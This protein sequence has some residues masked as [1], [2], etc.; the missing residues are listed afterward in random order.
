MHLQISPEVNAL[1]AAFAPY[2]QGRLALLDAMGLP[3]SN[4][5]PLAEF[6]EALAASVLG[7][8]LA[9]NRVQK[10]W[11]VTT[12]DARRVQ[13]KY[14]ANPAT[15]SWPNWHTV[16]RND[17]VNAY[18]LVIFEDLRPTA[19]YLFP[20]GDFGP[21]CAALG[22]RHANQDCELQFTQGNHAAIMRNPELFRSL[23]VQVLD[24]D[25][26]TDQVAAQ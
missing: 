1:L 26:A 19:V 11:D 10:D 15:G 5:D 24:L 2:R 6:S 3:H 25:G 14:L 8:S 18:C 17:R 21:L 23:G 4:R 12:S 20:L 13:V 16:R 9:T 22:K 7:G